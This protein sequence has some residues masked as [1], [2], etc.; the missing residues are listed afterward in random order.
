MS[1]GVVKFPI[2]VLTVTVVGLWAVWILD[3][4]W[5]LS[6]ER[7]FFFW[8]YLLVGVPLGARAVFIS[9]VVV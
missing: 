1:C 2:S 7:V 5:V 9:S 4:N 6:W 8:T 3:L